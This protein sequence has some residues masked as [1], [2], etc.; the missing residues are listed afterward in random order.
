MSVGPYA[1]TTLAN[2]KQYMGVAIE[3]DDARIER[4]IDRATEILERSLDRKVKSRTYSKEQYDGNGA[5]SLFLRNYPLGEVLALSAG[6]VD[7]ALFVRCSAPDAASAFVSISSTQAKLTIAGGA[8]AGPQ[9]LDLDDSATVEAL[10]AAIESLDGWTASAAPGA[11]GRQPCDLLPVDGVNALDQAAELPIIAQWAAAF[12]VDRDLGRVDCP[13]GFVRGR[14]N[15][16]VTYTAGFDPIPGD[17]EMAA[18]EIVVLLYDRRTKGLAAEDGAD[19][20]V[21]GS[22]LQAIVD[23]V[24]HWRRRKAG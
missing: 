11:A 20:K 3:S 19:H 5:E 10:A 2:A 1:L 6:G 16:V 12:H 13:G 14:G 23:S 24:G 9:T 17:L 8:K 15:V 7:S 18:L 4:L 21:P 22:A